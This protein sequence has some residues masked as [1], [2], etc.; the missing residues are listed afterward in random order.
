[1]LSPSS[2]GNDQPVVTNGAQ[3]EVPQVQYEDQ[4]V[5]V[6][7]QKQARGSATWGGLGE[8]FGSMD[9]FGP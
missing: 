6:P 5:H 9:D 3:V 7:V 1:M 8:D 2:S 4:I